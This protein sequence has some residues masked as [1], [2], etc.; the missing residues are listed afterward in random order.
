M[1]TSGGVDPRVRHEFHTCHVRGQATCSKRQSAE[2]KAKIF[3]FPV[4]AHADIFVSNSGY[5]GVD[6]A[7]AN[8]VPLVQCGSIFGKADIGRRV[9]YSGLGVYL[10]DQSRSPEAITAPVEEVWA[11]PKYKQRALKL[12]TESQ[13]YYPFK[14]VE[15]E[16]LA[17][18]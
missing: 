16:I 11:Q 1:R 13:T 9:E 6:Y 18:Y 12:R 5:G 15:K 10:P 8:S 4:L 17:Y 14:I 7:I 2:D 3:N